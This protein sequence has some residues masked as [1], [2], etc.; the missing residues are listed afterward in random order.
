[1][2]PAGANTIHPWGTESNYERFMEHL[3]NAHSAILTRNA[4]NE[5]NLVCLAQNI[6][7][8]AR[9]ERLLGQIAVVN[10][11][12]NRAQRRE[13][14]CTEV[15][16]RGQFSWT[17]RR[18]RMPSGEVWDRSLVLAWIALYDREIILDVT[19]NSRYFHSGNSTPRDFRNF[20]R[21][22]TIGNHRFYR[23]PRDIV[24]VAEAQ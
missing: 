21:T 15:F 6:Y 17:S 5:R 24:E 2:S 19:D 16:R 12:L 11:T 10:V 20:T 13:N 23:N 4:F 18:H 1:M 22:V 8:E 3:I 9:G 7:H 14:I